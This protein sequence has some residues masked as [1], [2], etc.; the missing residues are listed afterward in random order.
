MFFWRMSL[1]VKKEDYFEKLEQ[2]KTDLY[3]NERLDKLVT[4]GMLLLEKAGIE[5]NFEN[6]VVILHKLFPQKFSL[7]SFPQ[8]PDTIRVD[9]TLRLD[10]KHSK[11]VT[12]NRVKGFRLTTIG[13]NIAEDAIS[14]LKQGKRTTI[15]QKSSQRRGR[16]TRAISGVQESEAFQKYSTKKFKEIKKF[17]VCEVLHGTLDTDEESLKMNLSVLHQYANDIKNITQYKDLAISVLGFFDYIEK[18]WEAFF[19]E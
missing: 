16:A 8:Y 1:Q 6:I 19:H 4:V 14:D 15:K 10:C 7:I 3:Q 12:G 2:Y 18:N 17:D 5:K 11:F 9:N 13:R